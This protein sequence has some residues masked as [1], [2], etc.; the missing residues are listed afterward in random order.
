MGKVFK[1]LLVFLTVFLTCP[2]FAESSLIACDNPNASGSC[3]FIPESDSDADCRPTPLTFEGQSPDSGTYYLTAQ[4]EQDAYDVYYYRGTCE[5]DGNPYKYNGVG[6]YGPTD[7]YTILPASTSSTS[8][9]HGIYAANNMHFVN[10]SAYWVDKEVCEEGAS[11]VES[12]YSQSKSS[13]FPA[14]HYNAANGTADNDNSWNPGSFNWYDTNKNCLLLVAQC[15]EDASYT[16]TYKNGNCHSGTATEWTDSQNTTYLNGT[17]TIPGVNNGDITAVYS[18]GNDKEFIGWELDW[19]DGT[20]GDSLKNYG[21]SINWLRSSNLTLKAQCK[22]TYKLEYSCGVDPDTGSTI[23]GTAP[24]TSTGIHIEDSNVVTAG[25][26]TQ[27]NNGLLE[28]D[29]WYCV[30]KDHDNASDAGVFGTDGNFGAGVSLTNSWPAYDG[31]CTAMWKQTYSLTFDCE[32]GTASQAAHTSTLGGLTAETTVN[33]EN[34]AISTGGSMQIP[35][36]T[37]DNNTEQTGWSCNNGIVSVDDN[38]VLTMP[39]AD[40]TCTP[41]TQD[42]EYSITYNAVMLKDS[43]SSSVVTYSIYDS[44]NTVLNVTNRGDINWGGKNPSTYTVANTGNNSIVLHTGEPNDDAYRVRDTS[45]NAYSIIGKWYECNADG[46]PVG[47]TPNYIEN[48]VSDLNG[49]L[50]NLNLCIMVGRK[51]TYIGCK[52]TA[53]NNVKIMHD[54]LC[55][56]DLTS[57][58]RSGE[59]EST[60]KSTYY[61]TYNANRN[62]VEFPTS[63]GTNYGEIDVV[64]EAF[65]GNWFTFTADPYGEYAMNLVTMSY[66]V[67]TGLSDITVYTCLGDSYQVTYNCIKG[68]GGTH[69]DGPYQKTTISTRGRNTCPYEPGWT[70]KWNCG[71]SYTNVNPGG[72]I[73]VNEDKTC[74]AKWT[75]DVANGY[76]YDSATGTC[77]KKY[78][79]KFNCDNGVSSQN[80]IKTEKLLSDATYDTSSVQCTQKS[81]SEQGYTWNCT[82]NA[83]SGNTITMPSQDVTCTAQWTPIKYTVTYNSGSCGSDGHTSEDVYTSQNVTCGS[84]YSVPAAAN[85]AMNNVLKSNYTFKGW[86]TASGQEVAN[87]TGGTINSNITVYAACKP[88]QYNLKLRCNDGETADRTSSHNAGESVPLISNARNGCAVDT[89]GKTFIGW[90]CDPSDSYDNSNVTMNSDVVCDAHW[91]KKYHLTYNCANDK[92]GENPVDTGE[93]HGWYSAGDAVTTFTDTNPDTCQTPPLDGMRFNG[94]NC[95]DTNRNGTTGVMAMPEHDVKCTAQ[96][97]GRDFKVTYDCNGMTVT[98]GHVKNGTNTTDVHDNIKYGTDSFEFKTVDKIC[99]Y[100]HHNPADWRCVIDNPGGSNDRTVI[101]DINFGRP[102]TWN[103]AYDV[104]CT[105]D[106]TP[107]PVTLTYNCNN[108]GLGTTSRPGQNPEGGTYDYGTTV[109]MVEGDGGCKIPA[110]G[111]NFKGW[112]CN[113]DKPDDN[114]D[115]T[116]TTDTTCSADWDDMVYHLTYDCN[117]AQGG[118]GNPP[119]DEDENGNLIDRHYRDYFVIKSNTCK[120]YNGSSFASWKCN[121]EYT[122]EDFGYYMPAENVLCV[123]QWE[124]SPWKLTYNCNNNKQGKNPVGGTYYAGTPDVPVLSNTDYSTCKLPSA[125]KKFQGWNCGVEVINNSFT[126]P[127]H[128]VECVADWGDPVWPIT[129]IGCKTGNCL[130]CSSADK[131]TLNGYI[132]ISKQT[133]GPTTFPNIVFPVPNKSEDRTLVDV[134]ESEGYHFD[135]TWF[136]SIGNVY[137]DTG[138]LYNPLTLCTNL[139]P[140]YE[141]TY[142]CGWGYTAP[143]DENN[144]YVSGNDVTVKAGS[145][146]GAGSREGYTFTGW[147]CKPQAQS[148]FDIDAG[149]KF[150]IEADTT[151]TAQW[152]KNEYKV[153]Y[154][155]TERSTKSGA[156]MQY[157]VH[158]GDEHSVASVDDKCSYD[159]YTFNG[160]V[161]KKVNAGNVLGTYRCP[162]SLAD[163]PSCKGS[164]ITWAFD[165]D[166]KCDASWDANHY[167]VI[168]DKGEC[169]AVDGVAYEDNYNPDTQSGG[170]TTGR[171]YTVPDVATTSMVNAMKDGYTF[172]GWNTVSG[173]TEGNWTGE[174]PWTHREDLIVYAAC[175]ANKY[176]V[177]Y[178]K[179]NCVRNNG[180]SY[181]DTDGATYGER[182]NALSGAAT[183]IYAGTGYEFK[184]WSTKSTQTADDFDANG[185]LIDEWKGANP[186]ELTRDLDVYAVCTPMTYNVRYRNNT[187][188]GEQ[189]AIFNDKVEYDS[190]YTLLPL[191]IEWTTGT[192]NTV[193]RSIY[194]PVGYK[195]IGWKSLTTLM[196]PDYPD[197]YTFEPWN[198]T[199]TLDLF[200]ECVEEDYRVTYDCDT[201]GN[202]YDSYNSCNDSDETGCRTPEDDTI[203]HITDTVPVPLNEANTCKKTGYHFDKWNCVADDDNH[204]ELPISQNTNRFEMLAADARCTAQWIEDEYHVFYNCDSGTLCD[205]SDA[206]GCRTPEDNTA[207]HYD[208]DVITS[209]NQLNGQDACVKVGHYP[210]LWACDGGYKTE[211]V[212]PGDDFEDIRQDTTCTMQWEPY[213]YDVTYKAGTCGGTENVF[214]QSAVYGKTF[215]IKNITDTDMGNLYIQTGYEFLGWS[216]SP[217]NED[218]VEAD[219]F[220]VDY[221]A[222]DVSDT[223]ED[224]VTLYAVCKKKIYNICY[225]FQNTGAYFK[226]DVEPLME[227]TIA[228]EPKMA[229]VINAVHNGLWVFGGW[230]NNAEGVGEKV[231]WLPR[232]AELLEAPM[233]VQCSDT[234]YAQCDETMVSKCDVMLYAKWFAAGQINFD[235]AFEE[236]DNVVMED[237]DIIGRFTNA[238]TD[239]DCYNDLVKDCDLYA[240]DCDDQRYGQNGFVEADPDVEMEFYESKIVNCTAR[241]SCRGIERRINYEVYDADTGERIDTVYVGDSRVNVN[242]L[243][244]DTYTTAEAVYYPEI[245]LPG[246]VFVGDSWYEDRNFTKKTE[247]TPV[248]PDDIAEDEIPNDI[249]VYGKM[250]CG[251]HCNEPGH[252]HWFHIGNNPNDKV[253][254]YEEKPHTKD[255]PFVRVKGKEYNKPYYMMLSED[256]DMIIH[257]GSQKSM[258]IQYNGK[259][260]NVCDKSS[261]PDL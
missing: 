60:D 226:P 137:G 46:S 86:N 240:W 175:E 80:P 220:A 8:Q 124:A 185:D 84:N 227:Y 66:H 53:A 174:S 136:D 258:R 82:P 1:R 117:S 204:T 165:D 132:D 131:W 230:Y 146:C 148:A 49:D 254:L 212:V 194:V 168:Y 242:N 121:D 245:S 179:G 135:G 130:D 186:W 256:P 78:N 37:V 142:D 147:S 88:I 71:G 208:A 21:D 26:P 85:S 73:Y 252:E 30:K 231:T 99:E 59:I 244:P 83:L 184:G 236:G 29:H 159:G 3:G 155:C 222:R 243:M 31:L 167:N 126:M 43:S 228:T 79:L 183:S 229:K 169:G 209:D 213:K 233:S 57:R 10:W 160:W 35:T 109:P 123:A 17:Y 219:G 225:D 4:Y 205:N 138:G 202:P 103:R 111:K 12:A 176:T 47:T 247:H 253:C 128:N 20:T 197:G 18:E 65:D 40:V 232:D 192:N 261:C 257:E 102:E 259:I 196:E 206:V 48:I 62:N 9:L 24:S 122:G 162:A 158:Y 72:S 152:T 101:T 251:F 223:V 5:G 150:A 6:H 76:E 260:Y 249:T 96:W 19:G 116:L 203:Y 25:T 93:N 22:D 120:N 34:G 156:T 250:L 64:A 38:G 241:R 199:S 61:R 74:N 237:K 198:R 133:Y 89:D 56:T 44:T 94:W 67:G 239:D 39:S 129:Y 70:F 16:V 28:F 13:V 51:I 108:N 90:T 36:C 190:N 33:T 157:T 200:A 145:E 191:P 144:P 112:N 55:N 105:T 114:G 104:L 118:Y 210:T 107:E 58:V 143:I 97:T 248:A 180:D 100:E 216:K 125:D 54:T 172:K 110:T 115:I 23:G 171:T 195:F 7:G 15:T 163:D 177:T 141:V 45:A 119:R 221:V 207:Y 182:Y 164:S 41:I 32:D 52:C 106:W 238:K 127:N 170:A 178:N 193:E 153:T 235:C 87:W 98:G 27:C 42:R 173:E 181:A 139:R 92:P 134:L 255:L 11:S 14:G 188:G 161:C 63:V 201:I 151:C 189:G 149:E 224:N 234:I 215:E 68:T 113:P 69:V 187:C 246:C 81:C 140:Y 166:L 218:E 214:R 91:N 95:P 2:A 154:D 217:V 211:E 50:H 77:V 75:C